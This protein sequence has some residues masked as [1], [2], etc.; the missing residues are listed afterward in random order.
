MFQAL[1]NTLEITVLNKTNPV[2]KF[3]SII[4]SEKDKH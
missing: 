1:G 4:Y 3:I 2:P